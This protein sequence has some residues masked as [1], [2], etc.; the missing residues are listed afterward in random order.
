VSVMTGRACAVCGD[1]FEPAWAGAL[2]CSR[3]CTGKG[4]KFTIMPAETK[5]IRTAKMTQ[6]EFDAMLKVSKW[7]LDNEAAWAKKGLVANGE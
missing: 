6:A 1:A 2:Y 3:D 4:M 5:G 7:E